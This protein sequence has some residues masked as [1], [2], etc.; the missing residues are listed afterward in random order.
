MLNTEVEDLLRRLAP[1]VVQLLMRISDNP[2]A[3]NQAV[4]VAMARG[5]H[6]LLR[7]S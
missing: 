1:R 5:S 7:P 4:A 3:L 6:T 2:M